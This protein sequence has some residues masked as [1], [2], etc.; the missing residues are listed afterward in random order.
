MVELLVMVREHMP[1][2]VNNGGYGVDGK[3]KKKMSKCMR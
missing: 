2:V 1:I 3:K